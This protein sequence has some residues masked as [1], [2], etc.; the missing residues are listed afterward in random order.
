MDSKKKETQT[1]NFCGIKG[2][3]KDKCWKK[4]P[5]QMPEKIRV[6]RDKKKST[7]KVGAAV[8]EEH[9]LSFVNMCDEVILDTGASILFKWT[10]KMLMY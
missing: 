2:H 4:D 5:S 10:F 7:N 9:L 8:E 3:I 6:V 1:Y